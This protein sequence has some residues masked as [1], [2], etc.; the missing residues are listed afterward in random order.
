MFFYELAKDDSLF[1]I[2]MTVGVEHEKR[3]QEQREYVS[4][5]S[6]FPFSGKSYFS[7]EKRGMAQTG[8]RGTKIRKVLLISTKITNSFLENIQT[9]CFTCLS[10]DCSFA[11]V[12]GFSCTYRDA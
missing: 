6:Q 7:G 1:F 10:L 12:L 2:D 11:F 3:K 5:I 4:K 9:F 8:E